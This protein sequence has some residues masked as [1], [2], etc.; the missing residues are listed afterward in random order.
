[1]HYQQ[2]RLYHDKQMLHMGI[3]D[4]HEPGG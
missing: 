4:P 2:Q 3:T 1:L